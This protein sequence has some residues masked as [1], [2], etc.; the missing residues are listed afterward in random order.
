MSYKNNV[1]PLKPYS[2]GVSIIGVGAVP[3]M[4][5]MDDPETKGLT[6]GELFGYAAI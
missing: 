3:F 6:E 2:R 4:F 5:A 1:N